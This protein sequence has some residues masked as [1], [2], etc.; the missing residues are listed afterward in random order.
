[1]CIDG[2]ILQLLQNTHQQVQ[3]SVKM[4]GMDSKPCH[5]SIGVEQGCVLSPLQFNVYVSDILDF[6]DARHPVTVN[7]LT[8]N[9]LLFAD[10]QGAESI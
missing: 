2:N 7:S 8:T 1:M 10:D 5:S 3:Y 4:N 6:Y 9:S